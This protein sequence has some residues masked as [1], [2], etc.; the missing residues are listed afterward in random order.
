M[1]KIQQRQFSMLE[2]FV[3]NIILFYLLLIFVGYLS[4]LG[5]YKFFG[6]LYLTILQQKIML[7]YFLTN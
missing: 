2:R 1:K 6:S 4:T 3:G 7:P 5:Y